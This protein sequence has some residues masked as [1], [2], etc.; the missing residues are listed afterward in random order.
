MGRTTDV[1]SEKGTAAA[2][3]AADDLIFDSDF[4]QTAKIFHIALAPLHINSTVLKDALDL[5]AIFFKKII[6][7]R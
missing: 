5:L 4:T 1:F 6:Q 2:I 7:F 3:K